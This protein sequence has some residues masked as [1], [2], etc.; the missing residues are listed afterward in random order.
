LIGAVDALIDTY[1]HK[2]GPAQ[3]CA[4]WSRVPGPIPLI[5]RRLL[6]DADA[7]LAELG[8]CGLQGEHMVVV[9]N[10]A[11]VHKPRSL[12]T[13]FLLS[14]A[15]PRPAA[16]LVQIRAVPFEAVDRPARCPE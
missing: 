12:H 3:W 8:Y 6:S 4:G 13:V 15:G 16:L 10:S 14:M 11:G 1:E 5:S 9:E 2:I 7:A